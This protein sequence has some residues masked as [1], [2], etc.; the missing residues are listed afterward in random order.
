M[1]NDGGVLRSD[2]LLMVSLL[3]IVALLSSGCGAVYM[4]RQMQIKNDEQ[5]LMRMYRECIERYY[6][7]P[8]AIQKNCE[9]IVAPLRIRGLE[10]R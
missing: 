2:A 1:R 3:S 7:D 10:Q 5:K 8:D 9:P 4:Y 6:G